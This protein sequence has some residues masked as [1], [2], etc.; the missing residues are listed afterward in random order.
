MNKHCPHCGEKI[1]L[2]KR[3]FSLEGY[4]TKECPHCKKKIKLKLLR[5][6]PTAFC[7][8][9]V[10]CIYFVDLTWLRLIFAIGLV[11]FLTITS[12][13]APIISGEDED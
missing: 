11:V 9:L 2:I 3:L 7:V 8:A 1:S 12:I 13:L 5:F 4:H 10:L 6:W